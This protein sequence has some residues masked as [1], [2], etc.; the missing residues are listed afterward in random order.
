VGELKWFGGREATCWKICRMR[1]R[2]NACSGERDVSTSLLWLRNNAQHRAMGRGIRD[3]CIVL[4]GRCQ[5]IR[6]LRVRTFALFT[7]SC[8]VWTRGSRLW[9]DGGVSKESKNKFKQMSRCRH[10]RGYLLALYLFPSPPRRR[11]S[12]PLYVFHPQIT[13][14]L[15]WSCFSPAAASQRFACSCLTGF[16]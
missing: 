16:R 4:K 2:K 1:G 3:R 9:M 15:N 7:S 13:T 6:N 5:L 8:G 12:S 14:P 10:F 11:S